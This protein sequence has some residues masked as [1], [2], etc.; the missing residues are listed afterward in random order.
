MTF[1]RFTK[2]GRFYTPKASIW[3]RGQ[4]GFNQGAVDKFKLMDFDYAV[5]FYDKDEKKVGVQFT[6]DA[7]ESGVTKVVKGKTGVFV[8][9]R[10]FVNYYDIPHA[11]TKKYDV[12]Y[13]EDNQMYVFE[14]D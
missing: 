11:K 14:H 4:I 12:N 3:T 7:S 5:L 1:E 10:S 9:A 2:A 13:D 8:S 6:N